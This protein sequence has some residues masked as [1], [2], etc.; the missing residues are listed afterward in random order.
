MGR[1][2]ALTQLEEAKDKQNTSVIPPAKKPDAPVTPIA[3]EKYA[4]LLANQQTSKEVNQQDSKPVN[5]QTTEP[6]NQQASKV[7]NQQSSK[8]ALS[9]KEK[10]K[11]GT[12]LRPDSILK[13]QIQ[14]AQEQKKDHELLQE[15]VDLYYSP[16]EN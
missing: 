4:S 6:A 7:V 5:Q 14:A 15:I 1:F 8:L 3:K 12:Y 2:D 16:H 11:Y 13:I 10:R 9:T